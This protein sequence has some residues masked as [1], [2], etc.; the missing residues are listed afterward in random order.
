MSHGRSGRRANIHA[1]TCEKVSSSSCRVLC[2]GEIRLTGWNSL[3]FLVANSVV[4]ASAILL[5][6][7]LR[8]ADRVSKVLA[9]GT[10]AVSQIVLSLLFSGI[11]LQR[12]Q[13]WPVLSVNVLIFLGVLLLHT[14]V[15][16]NPNMPK[17]VAQ[18][19][20][21]SQS[22]MLSMLRHWRSKVPLI[23]HSVLILLVIA[24]V[25]WLLLRI[26]LFPPYA[27]D[28]L[29]YHLTT[30]GA[31]LQEGKITLT[32]FVLWTNVYP[33]NATLIYTW[34]AL[35][36]HNDM[37]VELGQVL[38]ALGGLGATAGIGRHMA[39]LSRVGAIAAGCL[40]FLTPIVLAQSNT[41]YTDVAL[42]SMF[43][44]HLFFV[45]R[46]VQHPCLAHIL[47]AG[48]AGGI[49]MG[50]KSTGVAY[51]GI[52]SLVLV[53][54]MHPLHLH[55]WRSGRSGRSG[56]AGHAGH[57]E[58]HGGSIVARLLVYGACLMLLGSFWYVR[59]WAVYGNPF[60]P[61]SVEV[62]GA[63][64]FAGATNVHSLETEQTPFLLQ[65]VPA[66]KQVWLSWLHEPAFYVYDQR[67]GGLG[68]QW[69]YLELPAMVALLVATLWKRQWWFV[70]VVLP[71]AMAFLVQP[72]HW[73]S[74]FT[75]A[76][77][78]P[79]AIAFVFI[80]EQAPYRRWYRMLAVFA[81]VLVLI[82]T[83]CCLRHAGLRTIVR[84][85]PQA[86]HKRT[87]GNLYYPE[88][89]WVNTVPDGARIGLHPGQHSF[90]YPLFGSRFQ[91]HVV[92]VQEDERD[93]FLE[94]LDEGHVA[95]MLVREGTDYDA[96]LRQSPDMFRQVDAHW[97]FHVWEV[98]EPHKGR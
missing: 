13:P 43:I 78:V 96:W 90:A 32:P 6:Q 23:P 37:I 5:T 18:A 77:V 12:L 48:L 17:P 47:L 61:Y 57:A 75:I 51:V 45:F 42:A 39:G 52:S 79:G 24:E 87:I 69:A 93:A 50:I 60:Y 84:T 89:R 68:L 98:V 34:L 76:S 38:F 31:W 15:G 58:Y 74:R 62:F 71:F 21:S 88:F 56:H 9:V 35:F 14:I 66:W 46:S 72:A 83:A 25:C 64:L 63:T 86:P 97:K 28:A 40:F 4:L 91:H 73:W 85:V 36:L 82:S 94:R 11:V 20:S 65:G 54:A 19:S 70:Y 80:L 67:L 81:L 44:V 49:T 27:W 3:L 53:L 33:H 55:P 95:Y 1:R 41:N 2:K 8:L 29:A 7:R 22:S 16:P 10:L 59:T 92:V 30:M 26:Y